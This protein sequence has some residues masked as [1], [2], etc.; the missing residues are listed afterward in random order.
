MFIN[1]DLCKGC[2][3]CITTCP[4]KV[5]NLS[6]TVNNSGNLFAQVDD[7][8]QCTR[9]TLCAIMCPEAAIT[10]QAKKKEQK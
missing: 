10:V 4:Q 6:Q 5:L 7:L 8:D 9:C 3:L 1:K 2:G